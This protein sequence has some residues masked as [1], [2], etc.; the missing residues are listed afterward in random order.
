MKIV[1]RIYRLFSSIDDSISLQLEEEFENR[2]NAYHW[3]SQ[4]TDGEYTLLEVYVNI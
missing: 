1:Y 4:H 3:I 2:I